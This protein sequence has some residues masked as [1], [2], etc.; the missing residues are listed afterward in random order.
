MAKSNSVNGGNDPATPLFEAFAGDPVRWRVADAAGDNVISFQVSG[1]EFPLDHGLTGS[2]D[3]E[4]RTLVPGE[5]FDAYLVNGA[6]GATGAT[7]DFEY[8]MGRDPIIKSGD[9]GIFRVFPDP[10]AGTNT[11]RNGVLHR[12]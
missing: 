1:H 8:N 3:I 9:W 11:Q 5:T 10:F 12:L 4:A 7:G 2:Q 6:G